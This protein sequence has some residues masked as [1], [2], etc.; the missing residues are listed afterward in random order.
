MYRDLSPSDQLLLDK[1]VKEIRER[2]KKGEIFSE[3]TL[4]PFG[5]VKP[6]DEKAFLGELRNVLVCNRILANLS[7]C[8]EV[9]KVNGS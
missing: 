6:E 7:L 8:I 5:F 4:V 1:V 3:V 9:Q 2:I